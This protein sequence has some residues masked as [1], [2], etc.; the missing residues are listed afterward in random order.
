MGKMLRSSNGTYLIPGIV[1][2]IFP[3]VG[4]LLK[5]Q[6]GKGVLFLGIY[7]VWGVIGFLFDLIPIFGGLAGFLVALFLW[8]V[9]VLDAFFHDQ[10]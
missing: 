6:I 3:G 7:L 9:N 2:A 8:G 5:R 1:S 10:S 4:Q